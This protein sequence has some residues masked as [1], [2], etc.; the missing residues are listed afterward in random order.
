MPTVVN[1]KGNNGK[2][3]SVNGN[4]ANAPNAPYDDGRP[5]AP[6]GLGGRPCVGRGV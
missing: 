5:P 4:N 6:R 1:G 3:D 2:G